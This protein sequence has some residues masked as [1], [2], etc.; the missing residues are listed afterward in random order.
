[1]LSA[2]RVT[3]ALV[4]HFDQAPP[5]KSCIYE[6]LYNMKHGQEARLKPDF[7]KYMIIY[8]GPPS[9]IS[10]ILIRDLKGVPRRTSCSLYGGVV[11]I[12]A[13]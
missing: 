4:G 11:I 13:S 7:G 3:L 10:I 9:I 12:Y 2:K 1:M 8:V 6:S 5:Q